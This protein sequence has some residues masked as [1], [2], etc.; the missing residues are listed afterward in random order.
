MESSFAMW[1][2][3]TFAGFDG[4][5]LEFYHWLCVRGFSRR[6]YDHRFDP[7]VLQRFLYDRIAPVL[8][9]V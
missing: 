5:I 9:A 1:L 8:Q 4:A 7:Y 3:Q 2:N 6:S